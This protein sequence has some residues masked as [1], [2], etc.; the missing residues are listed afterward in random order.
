MLCYWGKT[1]K[2][3]FITR[4]VDSPDPAFANYREI[5]D[6]QHWFNQDMANRVARAEATA[7]AGNLKL[8]AVLANQ[9]QILDNQ[10]QIFAAWAQIQSALACP[11]SARVSLSPNES[12]RATV[13]DTVSNKKRHPD[14][15]GLG[16]VQC[17]VKHTKGT[18]VASTGET[19]QFPVSQIV[20]DLYFPTRDPNTA[21]AGSNFHGEQRRL[22]TMT[23]PA[24]RE[25]DKLKL[26]MSLIEFV[27]TENQWQ[28]LCMK[29]QSLKRFA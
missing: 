7:E 17:L 9:Q 13:P 23:Y 14:D 27:I 12:S 28:Q 21:C 6:F 3:D 19:K 16:D 25:Q 1:I 11:V 26:V 4:N 10:Q 22:L 29:Q 8:N 18:D 20:V 24:L 2:E 15:N 5:L